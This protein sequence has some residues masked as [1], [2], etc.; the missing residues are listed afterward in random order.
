M[1]ENIFKIIISILAIAVIVFGIVSITYE[2]LDLDFNGG[3]CEV[4]GENVIPVA[5]AYSTDYYCPSCQ[6]YNTGR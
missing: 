2:G 4:C 6:R 3:K 5:H 1:S